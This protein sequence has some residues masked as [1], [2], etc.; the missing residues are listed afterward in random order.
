[1]HTLSGQVKCL[2][3]PSVLVILLLMGFRWGCWGFLMYALRPCF[4]DIFLIHKYAPTVSMYS[5][6]FTGWQPSPACAFWVVLT[7]WCLSHIRPGIESSYC[8]SYHNRVKSCLWKEC[9]NDKPH[10]KKPQSMEKK[11]RVQPA[12]NNGKILFKFLIKTREGQLL[13]IKVSFEIFFLM[14]F[15]VWIFPSIASTWQGFRGWWLQRIL[16]KVSVMSFEK[17]VC[18]NEAYGLS[19]PLHFLSL[20]LKRSKNVFSII[21]VVF[22]YSYL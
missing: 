17:Y 20:M 18:K 13:R 2:W 10:P 21:S 9:L 6:T 8:I 12:F 16:S 4:P 15:Q 22:I 14:I 11:N 3:V 7:R 1:M 5:D 19:V